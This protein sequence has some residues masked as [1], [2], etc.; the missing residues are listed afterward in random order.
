M[1]DGVPSEN[2]GSFIIKDANYSSVSESS[3]RF[4]LG[5]QKVQWASAIAEGCDWVE[6]LHRRW[7]A[8]LH[9]ILVA[10]NNG[11]V[12]GGHP[13]VSNLNITP[14]QCN[15]IVANPLTNYIRFTYTAPF[16]AQDLIN[17]PDNKDWCIQYPWMR[18]WMSPHN[19]YKVQD[20]DKMMHVNAQMTIAWHQFYN[21]T[22]MPRSR[23]I[24]IM[25][26]T[27]SDWSDMVLVSGF[28]SLKPGG[29]LS[30]NGHSKKPGT[31][32]AYHLW[33]KQGKRIDHTW[34]IVRMQRAMPFHLCALRFV[35]T[36]LLQSKQFFPSHDDAIHYS[37]IWGLWIIIQVNEWATGARTE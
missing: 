22:N 28:A 21:G 24:S 16:R 20:S 36:I 32:W 5:C 31:T 33:V 1:R 18:M 11:G 4:L 15:V 27:S 14:E 17:N 13:S 2:W 7:W 23:V 37:K 35:L 8:H 10:T 26:N 19:I 9:K 25:R 6:G 29:A 3:V 30:L 34:I 12:T